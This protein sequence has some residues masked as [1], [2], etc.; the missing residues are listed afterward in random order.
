MTNKNQMTWPEKV[1][2]LEE[3]LAKLS[4]KGAYWESMAQGVNK[5]AD[6][7]EAAA[8]IAESKGNDAAAHR[9]YKEAERARR[10][11]QKIRAG[12]TDEGEVRRTSC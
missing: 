7:K 3:Q 1:A 5:Y 9:L 11:A 10:F 4:S 12:G 2:V 6:I 8:G